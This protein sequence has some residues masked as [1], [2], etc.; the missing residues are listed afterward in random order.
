MR[1]FGGR[2]GKEEM[3]DLF[4]NVLIKKIYILISENKKTQKAVTLCKTN[5][6][7]IAGQ[8]SSLCDPGTR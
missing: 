8:R 2:K 7:H 1:R 5:I 3:I 6:L 4:L